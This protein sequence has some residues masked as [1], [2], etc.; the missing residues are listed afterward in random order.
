LTGRAGHGPVPEQ[1]HLQFGAD[2]ASQVAIS[3]AAAAAVARP[4]LRFSEP[5]GRAAGEVEATERGYTD[6]LT[7]ETAYTYHAR[8][9]HLE[10]DTGYCYQVKHDDAPPVSG[11]FRTGPR[12]R[13]AGFR[14]TSCGDQA[15]PEPVG[16]GPHSPNAGYVVSAIE[17]AQ[18]LF[19]LANGDLCYANITDQPVAAWAA[20]F[21]NIGRSA[22]FR[23]WMPALGNHENEVGNGS[24]GYLSYLTRFA[25]PG[26]GVA[27]FAGN[28]YAFTVGSVLVISLSND[29]V[30]LQDGGFSSYRRDHVPGYGDQGF[31]PYLHGYSGGRQRA[32]LEQVLATG[33]QSAEIDWIVVCMHQVAM[34]S[35]HFNGADL[36]IRREWLPLFDAY[37]VDLV[38]AGHEHHYERTRPVRG[39]LPGSELLTPAPAGS[40][41]AEVDPMDGT[42]HLTIGG[43]GHPF[44]APDRLRHE[45]GEG[46]VITGTG[47]GDPQRVRH[48]IVATEPAVWSAY[49]GEPGRFG[50]A[51][52]DVAPDEPGGTTSITGTYYEAMPGSP[53]YRPRDSFVLRKPIA[54]RPRYREPAVAAR[55]RQ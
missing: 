41:P 39:T 48:S 33:R 17:A 1:V 6:A 31:D 10:P 37:G 15:I 26:N 21:A 32:W 54:A 47:A 45:P 53:D 27:G 23:P 9:D 14:F 29:D 7:G 28:W 22:R 12:G 25:L 52:F 3:W 5:S 35:A 51:A 24:Q 8:L 42:V 40:D 13:S 50:F 55:C 36:G 38:L 43:A 16:T 11:S 30:C 19:H 4:R 20:Y 44:T 34:S 18:P 49:R 46:L 2:A